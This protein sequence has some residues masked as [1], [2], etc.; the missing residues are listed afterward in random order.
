MRIR[1]GAL[2]EAVHREEAARHGV[3]AASVHVYQVEAVV[4][5]MQGVASVES[6]GYVVVAEAVGV[7]AA[8]PRVVSQPLHGIAADGGR[9]A[10]LVVFQGVVH[11][12]CSVA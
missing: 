5:L 11:G 2:H 7:A 1:L 9:Q 4:V 12:A 8:A 3:V 6:R 10:A